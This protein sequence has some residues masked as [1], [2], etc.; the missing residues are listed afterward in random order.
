MFP[1][2]PRDLY[3]PEFSII[4]LLGFSVSKRMF[5]GMAQGIFCQTVLFASSPMKTLSLFQD[6]LSPFFCG[7]TSFYA[8]HIM[9][10]PSA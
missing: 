9:K 7:S 1:Y 3:C 6:I 5:P 8:S 2:S 10:L 4:S